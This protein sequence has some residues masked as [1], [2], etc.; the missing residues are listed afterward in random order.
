M[1]QYLIKDNPVWSLDFRQILSS[2]TDVFGG[3]SEKEIFIFKNN[4]FCDH[5]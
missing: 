5:C 1:Y 2:G 3:K 4:N